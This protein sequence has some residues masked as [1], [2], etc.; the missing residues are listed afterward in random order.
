MLHFMS[1]LSDY[2]GSQTCWL[3]MIA[4]KII[5]LEVE[6]PEEKEWEWEATTVSFFIQ[7]RTQK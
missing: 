2:M 4:H 3:N 1:I 6:P 7:G 5:L